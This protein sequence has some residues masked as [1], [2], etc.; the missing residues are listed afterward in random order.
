VIALLLLGI[1][2]PS[3]LLAAAVRRWIAPVP[4]RTALLFFLMTLAF[5]H[6]AVVTS[7]LP[8]PVDEAARGYP[9]HGVVG[10]VVSRNPLTNDT[11]KLFL[12]W[13]QVAREELAHGR[14]PLWNR[15]SFA[16]YPLL[17]NGESAPFSPL[18]LATLFVPLPKQIVAMAAL[19]IF[20]ALLFTF[21]FLK[22]ERA[23]DA[24]ATFGAVVFAFSTV[25]T[26]FLYYSTASVVAFLPAAAFAL[27]NAID[28]QTKA[29]IV[30]V[31]IVIATLLANGHPESVLHIAIGCGGIFIIEWVIAKPRLR[32]FAAPLI[33]VALGLALGAPAWVPVLE[34]VR[35]SERFATL[36][37]LPH[38]APMSLTA[39]WGL[40][41]PNGFGNP[42][43]HNWS[44]MYNY[45]GVAISYAGLL[46]LSF[47]LAAA[48]SSRTA[49]RDRMYI[50][51][52]AIF[53]LVAMDWSI[54]GHA[55]NAI[56]PFDIVANDKL[57]FVCIFLVAVVAAK[58]L[59]RSVS[60]PGA[61]A[62]TD[63]EGLPE[64][65]A[66]H[67]GGVQEISRWQAPQARSHR[68]AIPNESHPGRGAGESFATPAGV[69]ETEPWY[70]WRHAF[71]A[72]HRLISVTP[73]AWATSIAVIALALY[74]FSIRSNLMRPIDLLGVAAIVIFLILPKRFRAWGAVALAFVELFAFNAGFNALVDAKYFRPPLPIVDALREHA[75]REPFRVAGLNWA[76][77]PNA[78]AQYG[79]EDV[80]GSDPMAFA[81]YD[82]FLQRFT[83]AETGSW[84]RR[85]VDAN[86]PEL[87]FLNV[88]FL[89][90]E[91]DANPGGRWQLIYRGVDGTLW[92]NPTALPRFF[93]R[94][95]EVRN[96][97]NTAPGEFTMTVV[98]PAPALVESS[99]PLGPGRRVYVNGRRV[100]PRHIESAFLGFDVPAGQS[101]VR[102]V[103]RPMTF[104]ASCVIALLA[105]IGIAIAPFPSRLR[106]FA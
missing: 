15:Y 28:K 96:L 8:V 76:F 72:C 81:D 2:I 74:V 69:G 30:F 23:S 22:R 16:G 98:S 85:I 79:L 89:L 39:A 53:F 94:A 95:A 60:V 34:Q 103:Y 11:V 14:A 84:V 58:W 17:A 41:S 54:V 104:Y 44:W 38:V 24:A 57:R 63:V 18:F 26:V 35:I 29:S 77:L 36:H 12:P 99:E 86:R 80:R 32:S 1:L 33:G 10:D 90:G 37:T 101:E 43:R 7:K 91:P 75:P 47:F 97:R 71:G 3:A 46:P 105:I 59:D 27:L 48:I 40:I 66:A 4:W 87:D 42:L 102:V 21:L 65:P 82:R 61:I 92:E 9:W 106:D 19:K 88:R 20:A 73:P 93:S 25:M 70:R 55:L 67:A 56:P 78:S 64:G 13:M 49:A 62:A 51:L 31:A 100:P 52:A 5:L 68:I 50:L 45:V 83:I 6:G